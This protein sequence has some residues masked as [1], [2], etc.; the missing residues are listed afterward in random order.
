[1]DAER[2]DINRDRWQ[3]VDRMGDTMTELALRTFRWQTGTR[4]LSDRAA[5]TETMAEF[6]DMV[7][8]VRKVVHHRITE[9]VLAR[10]R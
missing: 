8:A 4:G 5:M 1:M 7:A 6:D 3:S 9:E 2:T 10:R